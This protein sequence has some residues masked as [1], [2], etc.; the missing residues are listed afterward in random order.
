MEK[1]FAK[2]FSKEWVEAWNSHN[3]NKI[4]SH[5]TDDF[6]MNS[7]IIKEL[8]NEP[9]GKLNGKEV[10]KEYWSKALRLNPNLHFEI[11]AVFTGVKSIIIHYKGHRGLSAEIFY[12][13]NCNL[14]I[15]SYAHY[16]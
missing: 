11:L 10:I 1:S 4:L 12:F 15:K 2:I 3:L 16:E 5:Y 6:E 7:P 14:V 8:F 13:N 9:S